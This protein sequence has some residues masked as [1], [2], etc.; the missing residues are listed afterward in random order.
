MPEKRKTYTK[1]EIDGFDSAVLLSISVSILGM[2][3]VTH[4]LRSVLRL[5]TFINHFHHH[6][7]LYKTF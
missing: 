6:P 1:V 5:E 7:P 3:L 2:V 4:N